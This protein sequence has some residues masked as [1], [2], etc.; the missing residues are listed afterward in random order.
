MQPMLPLTGHA[1][2]VVQREEIPPVLRDEAHRLKNKAYL[3]VWHEVGDR[4]AR[5]AWSND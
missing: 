3:I 4:E 2:V 5:E 1:A